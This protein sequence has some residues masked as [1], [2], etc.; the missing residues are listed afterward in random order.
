MRMTLVQYL[1]RFVHYEAYSPSHRLVYFMCCE[2]F[3]ASHMSCALRDR[4]ITDTVDSTK[5]VPI[6]LVAS[7]QNTPG[8]MSEYPIGLFMN[9]PMG[10][11]TWV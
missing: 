3:S 5:P 6:S 8:S 7:F 9:M 1:T 4:P 2:A 10:K 11:L